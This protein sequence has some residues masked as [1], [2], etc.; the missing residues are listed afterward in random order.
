MPKS[1]QIENTTVTSL[2]ADDKNFNKGSEVG[3]EMIRKSFQ[4]FGAGYFRR[5]P[6][7]HENSTFD[8]KQFM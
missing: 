8:F 6:Q 1:K 3:A 4:K 5:V 7:V 2:I